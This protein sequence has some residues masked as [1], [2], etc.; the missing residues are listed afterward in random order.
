MTQ[1]SQTP[2]KGSTGNLFLGRSACTQGTAR[3][4]RLLAGEELSCFVEQ[5]HME[6]QICFNFYAS[7]FCP[8]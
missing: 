4:P 8:G 6:K 1:S 7:F 5:I 3:Q 2:A